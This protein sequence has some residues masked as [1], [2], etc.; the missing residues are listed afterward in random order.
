MKED[1]I[2]EM[3]ITTIPV[4][5][6]EGIS[7]LVNYIHPPGSDVSNHRSLQM[8]LYSHII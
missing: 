6:G 7:L 8:Q 2:D 1:L 4:V 5:L 3:I